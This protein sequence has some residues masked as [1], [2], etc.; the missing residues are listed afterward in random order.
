MFS[1]TKTVKTLHMRRGDNM[2][3]GEQNFRHDVKHVKQIYSFTVCRNI[4]DGGKRVNQ[5]IIYVTSLE[6]R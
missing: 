6:S 1:K 4:L 3:R 2:R 5:M